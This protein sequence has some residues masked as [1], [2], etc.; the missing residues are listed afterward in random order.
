MASYLSTTRRPSWG[1]LAILV[2]LAHPLPAQDEA[3][4]V[5]PEIQRMVRD[6][7]ARA[8]EAETAKHPDNLQA[9]IQLGNLYFDNGF[10]E[11]AVIAYEKAVELDPR[12]PDVLT[13]IGVVYRRTSRPHKAVQFFDRAIAVDPSHETSRFNKG[14]VL[15]HDLQD[16]DGALKAWEALLAINPVFVAPNGQSLDAILRHYS[17]AT[18]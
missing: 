7:M 4:Q 9:W 13:D 2:I 17:S 6:G 18:Q 1:C 11:K 12:N 5:P 15:M 16:R 14:I 10:Y 3:D 8:L